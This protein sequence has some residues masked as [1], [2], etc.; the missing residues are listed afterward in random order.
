MPAKSP[1]TGREP[2]PAFAEQGRGDRGRAV[3][4]RRR[5]GHANGY[6]H[7]A[8]LWSRHRCG[9][10]TGSPPQPLPTQNASHQGHQDPALGS[11]CSSAPSSSTWRSRCR[12]LRPDTRVA[13]GTRAVRQVAGPQRYLPLISLVN[14]TLWESVRGF[15]C[16][17]I[18]L[19]SKTSH[20]NSITG[21]AL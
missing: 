16:S 2:G 10:V 19:K 18:L 12:P 15:C 21:C 20:T 9:D 8:E 14:L 11:G 4:V 1:R 13:A 5:E 17:S 7:A 6:G 3:M